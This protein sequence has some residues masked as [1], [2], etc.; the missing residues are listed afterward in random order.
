MDPELP[1]N[2]QEI[3]IGSLA[4]R[5]RLVSYGNYVMLVTGVSGVIGMVESSAQSRDFYSLLFSQLAI[6]VFGFCA[7]VGWRN[8]GIIGAVTHRYTMAALLILTVFG[9]SVSTVLGLSLAFTAKL[10]D[11]ALKSGIAGII[12]MGF[13]SVTSLVTAIALYFL[14]R[15][16]VASM[17]LPLTSFL[18]R[19]LV[20]PP[21]D[22]RPPAKNALRGALYLGLG[23]LWF[24]LFD[25]IPDD[26]AY[27]VKSGS[28]NYQAF[29]RLYQLGFM[30]FL[31]SRHHFEPDF[32]SLTEY[33]HR[34]PILFLRSFSDDEK[35]DYN[36]SDKAWVDFS[37]E[38][39]LAGHFSA[40]G[41]FVAIGEPK[42]KLPH[43]GAIRVQL[44]DDEW[45]GRVGTLME[46][47]ALLVLMAGTTHWIEWELNKVVSS[48]Y[49]TKLV[50]IF[51]QRKTKKK[52]KKRWFRKH[53]AASPD[54]RLA[55]IK[56]AFTDTI[57]SS[58]LDRIATP[59]D[60]RAIGFG[61]NGE[62]TCVT[63]T[64]RNRESYQLGAL[65]I[66]DSIMRRDLPATEEPIR[67]NARDRLG[68]VVARGCA[69]AVDG[70]FLVGAYA[71]L[72][73]AG[74]PAAGFLA[75]GI[76]ASL[77]W[78]SEGLAGTTP[79]KSLFSLQVEAV[80]GGS[81]G[82]T[83]S[84]I[85]NAVRVADA[86]G[87]YIVGFIV[88][89][90]SPKRQRWGD[91]LAGTMV[92]TA[93]LSWLRRWA[94]AVLLGLVLIMACYLEAS[95]GP[96]SLND[97]LNP[98]EPVPAQFL[99][100]PS[101]TSLRVGNFGFL[102]GR[103]GPKR[104][105]TSFI[106]GE[107]VSIAYDI[108]G[109]A[110]TSDQTAKVVTETTLRDPNASIVLSARTEF[111]GLI[112]QNQ[113]IHAWAALPIPIFAPP[114][115]YRVS[116][117]IRD[118]ISDRT[119]TLEP[120]F[121]VWWRKGSPAPVAGLGIVE[122]ALSSPG[123]TPAEEITVHGKATIQ[124]TCS[125]SGLAFMGDRRAFR[126]GLVVTG[127]RGNAVFSDLNFIRDDA[128]VLYHPPGYLE[129]LEGGLDIPA[130]FEPGLYTERYT[131]TD[132]IARRT[133]MRTIRFRVE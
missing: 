68:H 10:D 80:G 90:A 67:T 57:W 116:I 125:V 50:L 130:S 41:P 53:P 123:S 13:A 106:P 127:P 122:L 98:L 26:I 30:F 6:G 51:P 65:I 47:A 118:T 29:N 96:F 131:V 71:L 56:R 107:K 62:V 70:L 12:G 3:D 7:W 97:V 15:S 9:F 22:Y 8:I 44:S 115:E 87:F 76:W 54:E 77:Y 49:A 32:D 2:F 55:V 111:K 45:Q 52:Q 128:E 24:L 1:E 113:R 40:C 17:G 132:E 33:D 16:Q 81:C 35:A 101:S 18:R 110:R 60:V 19:A 94:A 64:S 79:G 69:A 4:S 129:A 58:G 5:L 109:F 89:D 48:G 108:A 105:S 95:S 126:V 119:L 43:L 14:R 99:V 78:L 133:A 102:E 38:S 100:E 104:S 82:L 66:H 39:R 103:G 74:A 59:D 83:R 25:L 42:D 93:Q 34:P 63:S 120:R 73:F 91:R 112:D 28:N 88:A 92:T 114:G 75:L 72:T 21:E 84:A 124:M 117:V 11:Q 121:S 31:Y 37:L 27:G 23:V 85:R 46:D 86:A 36:S 20:P 61:A